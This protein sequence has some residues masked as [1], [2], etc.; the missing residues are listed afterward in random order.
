MNYEET[1]TRE[2]RERVQRYCYWI[3]ALFATLMFL[4]CSYV[5][6]V[7]GMYPQHQLLLISSA[8]AVVIAALIVGLWKFRTREAPLAKW[9]FG[10]VIGVILLLEVAECFIGIFK[11][12]P[13]I[14][15]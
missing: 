5:S 11:V 13:Q 3:S 10:P 1:R 7:P 6:M 2:R 12:L 9:P 4:A 14:I 15:R 8:A